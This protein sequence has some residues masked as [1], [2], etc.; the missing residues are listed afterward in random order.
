M[1]RVIY[2]LSFQVVTK[3]QRVEVESEETKELLDQVSQEKGKLQSEME[4]LQAQS[5]QEKSDFTKQKEALESEMSKLQ[6]EV[7]DLK[8][9]S[10]SEREQLLADV[11]KLQEQLAETKKTL[12]SDNQEKGS[13]LEKVSSEKVAL[14]AE[15]ATMKMKVKEK[16]SHVE[17]AE[18]KAEE[19]QRQVYLF[20]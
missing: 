17:A 3:V 13:I 18:S 20:E 4:Q 7:S 8:A 1:I 9:S 6:A 10:A 19:I 5:D 12:E 16:E 11:A 14:E 2:I 15:V